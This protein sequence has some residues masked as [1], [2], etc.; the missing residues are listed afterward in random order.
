MP[1]ILIANGLLYDGTGKEPFFGSVLINDDR[2]SKIFRGKTDLKQ[3]K[4]KSGLMLINAAGRAVT[5]GFIDIHRHCDIQ[6]FFG[7]GFGVPVLAQGITTVVAGNCGFSMT[8]VSEDEKIA[9]ETYSFAEPVLGKPYR[10]IK[11]FE[12]YMNYLDQARLPVNFVSMIGCGTVKTAVKGFSSV[13]FTDEE[14]EKAVRYINDALAVGAAGVSAGIMYI[15]ECYN[16]VNDYVRMLKPLKKYGVPLCVHMRGEGDSLTASVKEV[17]EIGKLAECPIEISHFKSCGKENWRK[18]IYNAIQLIEDARYRGQDVTCDFYPYDGGSTS[19]TTMIP[20][21]F[22]AGDM[23]RALFDLGTKEGLEKFKRALGHKW[24]SWDNY[25]ITLGWERIII[26]GVNKAENQRFVGK[27]VSDAAKDSG[28]ESAADFAAWIMNDEDGKVA[29]INMSMCQEDIDEVAK[30]PYSCVI[31]DSIYAETDKPHPRMYGA[32]PKILR[33]YV[34]ER[35]VLSME[36]A[37]YKM[38]ALPAMRMKIAGRGKLEEGY[39]ADINIFDPVKFKD[40]AT[41]DKPAQLAEGLEK[42]FVNGK[43]AWED[44]KICDDGCGKN[45]RRR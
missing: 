35:H 21:E 14:M 32:F 20:P 13:P 31:S 16:S 29:I 40:T 1:E 27:K 42:C 23:Q 17:I 30:L 24:S 19:M 33:E 37:I 2:I 26:S 38:T 22:V 41:Y 6:P 3:W 36:N 12:E 10:K 25:A 44:G 28:F 8:P 9:E 43:L 39:F 34:R 45:L 15:P 7:T 18:E 11:R 5:P 4:K